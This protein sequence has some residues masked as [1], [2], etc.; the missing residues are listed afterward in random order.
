MSYKM[1]DVNNKVKLIDLH[2][3]RRIQMVSSHQKR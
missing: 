2:V 3:H 1:G